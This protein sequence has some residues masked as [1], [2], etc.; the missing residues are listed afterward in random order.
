MS[1]FVHPILARASM[2]KFKTWHP[3]LECMTKNFTFE[4]KVGVLMS[5]IIVRLI[6]IHF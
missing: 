3:F 4:N 5:S 1:E 6:L 2:L